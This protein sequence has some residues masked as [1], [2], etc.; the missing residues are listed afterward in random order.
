MTIGYSDCGILGYGCSRSSL[1]FGDDPLSEDGLTSC[2]LHYHRRMASNNSTTPI[3][4]GRVRITNDRNGDTYVPEYVSSADMIT[5]AIERRE[6]YEYETRVNNLAEM[7]A[8]YTLSDL[9]IRFSS[10]T[11]QWRLD[12]NNYRFTGGTVFLELVITIY[13]TTEA[14]N[15]PRCRGLIMDHEMQHVNDEDTLITQTLPQRLPRVPFVN[16]DFT[17]AIPEREFG[18]R[19]RGSGE[20][21]GSDLER[22]I[23]RFVWIPAS[24]NLATILHNEHPEHGVEIQQCL[25]E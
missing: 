3:F 18:R 6:R 17:T 23:Q 12:G 13:V 16:S 25:R 5:L 24:S 22:M 21:R 15:K 20:G 10:L 14:I 19:I 2:N 7:P 4:V 8:G 11:R 9:N 1:G